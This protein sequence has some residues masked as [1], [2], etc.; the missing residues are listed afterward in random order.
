MDNYPITNVIF[1]QIHLS[2]SAMTHIA[3]DG[4][5]FFDQIN[6]YLCV[7]D[8][9][10]VQDAFA[11][12]RRA[13][14]DQRRKSGELFFTHPLTVAYYLSEYQL[15]APALIAA[16]L[17]DVAEDTRVTLPEIKSQFGKEVAR[18]VDG[19]TKLKDVTKGVAEGKSLSNKEIEDAT[20][21]K[22]LGTMTVDVRAVIIKLFDRL[23]NMRT[24]KFTPPHRQ[25]YKANETLA[26][27]APLANRLGVW[28]LKNELE[29]LALEVLENDTY[30]IIKQQ[31]KQL[32]QEQQADF[33]IISGQIFNVL[34]Q[35]NIDIRNV[36]Y[37]PENIYTIYQDLCRNE[38]S[39]Y[40]L[41]ETMRLVVLVDDLPSCYLALGH[42]HQLWPPIPKQFD[43]YI[44][45]PRDNLYRSL[46]TSV[47]HSEG[48]HLKLRFRTVAMDKVDEI[49]ILTRWLY[50]GTPL[51]TSGIANRINNF[52]ENINEN[53][54]L[55]QTPGAVV[56]GV[57]EDVF[58][59]QIRMY[60]PRGE[61]RELP[62][63]ATALDFAY[64]I[65]T[66][67]GDQCYA[68]VVN[69]EL[70]PLNKSLSDGDRV[71]IVKK[72]RAQP[73]RAWLDE[74]LGYIFT[75][76]AR[77]HARRWFRRLTTNTAVSQGEQLLNKELHM[78]GFPH[79]GHGRI[80]EMFGFDTTEELYHELGRAE[81]LPTTVALRVLE[82][83][84][85]AG[86]ARA[87]DNEVFS[88]MGKRYVVTNADGSNLRLCGTCQPRPPDNII[89][90]LRKNGGVT[91]HKKNCHTLNP[92]RLW[93]RSFKLGWGEAPREARSVDVEVKVYDRPGLL[94]E[95]THLIQDE[96]IN[97][98]YIH[99]PPSEKK[100]EVYIDL[101]IDVV[102]PR[103]LVRILHQIQALANVFSV[104]SFLKRDKP[105]E[106]LPAK[107]FYRPE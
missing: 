14:G 24:I 107:S 72:I 31:R 16:L 18:L 90:Y 103:Q 93:G 75:H 86:P 10:V 13:H 62:E 25:R 9:I 26:V 79:Y 100:N 46:H 36:I 32:K 61:L 35:A 23:H 65:H 68:A 27:Y 66:G 2:L 101:M 6:S 5:H 99:T 58:V 87:L 57:V 30:Q 81:L 51:W 71:R 52:F 98:S 67:L 38:L 92:E 44:A 70:Y 97:I 88:A 39:F 83:N 29:A 45:V 11:L 22:M 105:E 85:S 89:G 77:Y 59:K 63:G 40:D 50:K 96:H 42:L 15:D 56:K 78:L 17:H 48:R 104:Q 1:R 73:Q 12:A 76:Y 28:K 64:A 53:I 106:L 102:K 37:A 60:T 95:I 4:K 80:A 7:D 21:H 84:W 49:G 3:A 8:R 69:D 33:Q 41:D 43:D 74:D 82:E 20:L 19:V 94:F 34:L 55:E 54:R 91:V 47:I